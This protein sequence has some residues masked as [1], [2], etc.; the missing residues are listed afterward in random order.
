M[1]KISSN[2]IKILDGVLLSF[3]SENILRGFSFGFSN[4]W[5]PLLDLYES[6]NKSSNNFWMIGME[7]SEVYGIELPKIH[8]VPLVSHKY[9]IITHK[10]KIPLAANQLSNGELKNNETNATEN[11]PNKFS[12]LTN[13]FFLDHD[14]WRNEKYS[15]IKE[16]RSIKNA[17]YY[18]TDNIKDDTM[19]N[20]KKK[21][22]DKQV[23]NLMKDF[24]LSKE[25]E[26]T[27]DL[28]DSLTLK[29]SKDLAIQLAEGM[30]KYE[31]A[32][33]MKNKLKLE[34]M[35]SSYN[36]SKTIINYAPNNVKN[37]TMFN[38]P[39]TKERD[40]NNE[41][42]SDKFSGMNIVSNNNNKSSANIFGTNT[43]GSLAMKIDSYKNL[44]DEVR[45]EME[46]LLEGNEFAPNNEDLNSVGQKVLKDF[47]VLD[48]KSVIFYFSHIYV[49]NKILL[50]ILK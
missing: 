31:L 9:S 30:E 25:S 8:D 42:F 19:L 12:C 34:G 50:F 15:R 6:Y 10:L 11:E 13:L 43:L 28:F 45:D 49:S 22:H 39:F 32:E 18:Y 29:K 36:N 4:N 7:D 44:E 14:K 2:K 20:L 16:L 5:I 37:T 41:K 33:F 23:L 38:D 21:E 1:N 40:T 17:D 35:I 47:S 26:K 27:I 46:N 48:R 24:L 3:D